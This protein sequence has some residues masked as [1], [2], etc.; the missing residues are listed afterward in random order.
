MLFRSYHTPTCNTPRTAPAKMT[1]EHSTISKRFKKLFFFFFRSLFRA[2]IPRTENRRSYADHVATL[3]YTEPIIS[4]HAHRHDTSTTA[5]DAAQPLVRQVD[6]VQTDTGM[7]FLKKSMHPESDRRG[8][9][10]IR[11]HLQCILNFIPVILPVCPV[12]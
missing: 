2:I 4:A 12:Q 7:E 1:I 6:I 8:S 10:A 9:A 11:L 5:H 3:F